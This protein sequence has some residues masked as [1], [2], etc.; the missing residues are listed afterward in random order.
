MGSKKGRK[1]EGE[2]SEERGR[3]GEGRNGRPGKVASWLL[4]DGRPCVI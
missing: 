4:G 1:R 3:D 2:E